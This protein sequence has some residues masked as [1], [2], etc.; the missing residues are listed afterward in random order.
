MPSIYFTPNPNA[1]SN[2]SPNPLL[3]NNKEEINLASPVY[4]EKD[5]DYLKHLQTRLF[6]A[7]Q[8]KDQLYP[9]WN[10]K[11]YYTIFDEDEKIANTNHLEPK[12]N[13]DDVIISAGTIETKLDA[14][15]SN[16]HNLNLSPE[17][18]A[19]DKDNQKLV[20]LA[21][22][23]EDIIHDA[24]ILD[25]A[26]GAGDAEKKIIRQRELLKHGTVL[27]QESWLRKFETKK[28]LKEE[29]D[30]A[31][32]NFKGYDEALE[33]VFEGPEGSLVYGPNFFPG[34]VTQFYQENQP[35]I[36]A[37]EILDYDIAEKK[38]GKFENWKYV[39][40][41]NISDT[42]SDT[43]RSIFNNKWRL[44]MLRA[45]QVEII[46]Y[47]DQPHDEFQIL[48]NSVCMLPIG[49][50]LSAVT[51]LGK[52][53]I[54]KQVFRIINEKFY[55]GGSFVA[56]GSVKE[57]S[58]IIDEMLK[59]FVLKTRKSITPAYVNTS[60]RVI[61]RKALSPGRISMGIEAGALQPI[62][63]NEV[64]GVTNGEI[65]VLQQL[66][67]LI[68]R[69]TVSP[70]FT[71][72]P[73]DKGNQTA[74]EILS[75]EKQARAYL[76]LTIAACSF[77]EQKV[78]TLRLW[79]IYS[80]W[81]KPID[82]KVVVLEGDRKELKDVYR[83]TN[84]E[85]NIPGAGMGERNVIVAE[86]NLP[87]PQ[88]IRNLE[89]QEEKSKGYPIRYIYVS[90]KALME[91]IKSMYIVINPKEKESSALSKLMFRDELEGLISLIQLG[92]RP[93]MD[94]I[95][96]DFATIWG[97]SRSKLFQKATITPD[98]VAALNGQ[99]DISGGPVNRVKGISNAAGVPKNS[100]I[101]IA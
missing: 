3:K 76:G 94:T 7:K 73:G 24:D 50:P 72:Q 60:G 44:Q 90:A 101:P 27:Y 51:P 8:Q 41:G 40:P 95:E 54:A 49:F 56:S 92:S 18:L 82:S 22:A 70:Q 59:L 77:L 4:E 47:Q 68:D 81:F 80:N 46:T 29:Y 53:N 86:D 66:Q 83:K 32:K 74:T 16:I 58:A 85:V 69:S 78:K 89:R 19:F 2:S 67:T 100:N 14:L 17:V 45:N 11:N 36:F 88:A 15:L 1:I 33:L 71:G 61:D 64:Q 28:K 42:L 93:N 65:N 48:I 91:R 96:Q 30:G 79:N 13:E 35:F 38:Y 6:N 12:K 97:K 87:D 23:L 37:V 21:Q 9:E 98:Q 26:D 52:Y 25:G 39:K 75:L 43:Q 84:R 31:W 55:W 99:K 10:N 57:I 62:A 5:Q 20:A 34:D 63:G